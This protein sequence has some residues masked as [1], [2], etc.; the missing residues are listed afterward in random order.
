MNPLL[1]VDD[2]ESAARERLDASIFDYVAGGAGDE[3][4]LEGNRSAF[5]RWRLRPRVM[6]NVEHRDLRVSI[7]GETLSLPIGIA[8]SAFHKLIH[9]D[10]ELATARAAGGSGTVMCLSVMATVSLEEV[11]A[12]ASGPL[13]LQTYIFRDRTFTTDLAERARVA[14]YRALVLTVDT[15][16]LGR[17]ER[18]FRNHFELPPGIE[19]RNINFPAAI[20]GSYESP[21]VRFSREQFDP[22]LTWSDVDWFV[23]S[24]PMP[25]LVKGVLHPDDARRAVESGASGVIVSNHGGRQLD[26]AIATLDALPDIVAAV[27]GTSAAVIV[28]GGIRRGTDVVKAL[29]LGARLVMVGRPVLWGLAVDGE[30][31][32]LAVLEILRAEVDTALALVGCTHPSDLDRRYLSRQQS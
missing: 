17:R 31:G 27:N 25:V 11:A 18:D 2:Y 1:N 12:V 13:W 6:V 26:G 28:D 5:D 29:A 24:V 8:P 19:M 4:T 9:L 14:G 3:V 20:P 10:G 32:A 30:A 23:Q 22:S 15:P 7:L 16:V 21:M